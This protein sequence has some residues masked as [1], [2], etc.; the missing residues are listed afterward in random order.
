MASLPNTS[1][2]MRK[3]QAAE[4]RK[5]LLLSAKT[6]FAQ[7]GY[8]GT[9]V[10]S[11]NREV[12]MADGILYHH[13]PGGKREIFSVLLEESFAERIQQLNKFNAD[14]DSLPLE[15]ALNKIYIMGNELFAGDL[16]LMKILFS[17]HHLMDL[18]ETTQLS[19]LLQERLSWF[20]EFLSRRYE[21]GEIRKIDF[22]AAATQFMAM[23]IMN[24]LNKFTGIA[25]T[26]ILSEDSYRKQIVNYT[27][28]LWRKP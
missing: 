4:T 23:S 10:R 25:L 21:R 17:E 26:G 12:N 20:E 27:V 8:K 28:D 3:V 15:E 6:L 18:K 11:I 9:S 22:Q 13:F 19:T 7:K 24:V 16:D 2:N 5:K 1:H 14:L